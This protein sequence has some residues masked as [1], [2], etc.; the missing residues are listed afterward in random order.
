MRGRFKEE[1]KEN[2]GANEFYSEPVRDGPQN[3]IGYRSHVLVEVQRIYDP[4]PAMR[5]G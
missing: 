2:G 1:R 5:E 4:V 3:R